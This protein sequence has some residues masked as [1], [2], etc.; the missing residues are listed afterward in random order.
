MK[1]RS[2]IKRLLFA[3]LLACMAT[4][5]AFNQPEIQEDIR[6]KDQTGNGNHLKPTNEL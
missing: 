6:W 1:R 4:E 5:L 2:L 3:P